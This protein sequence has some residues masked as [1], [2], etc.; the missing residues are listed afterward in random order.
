MKYFSQKLSNSVR[1]LDYY[2]RDYIVFKILDL[3]KTGIVNKTAG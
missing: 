2:V 3:K 1:T